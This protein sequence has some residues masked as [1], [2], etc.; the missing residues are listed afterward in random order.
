[1]ENFKIEDKQG[2][3]EVKAKAG[4]EEVLEKQDSEEVE[5]IKTGDKVGLEVKVNV[6]DSEGLEMKNK[7][8]LE[9]KVKENPEGLEGYEEMKVVEGMEVVKN[10][11]NL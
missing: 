10:Q 11:E 6:K 2:L 5:I 9:V 8:G 1:M 3:E 7:V 4:L